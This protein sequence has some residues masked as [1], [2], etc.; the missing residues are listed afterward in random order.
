MN[1]YWQILI[2][3]VLGAAVIFL[4][5]RKRAMAPE[6]TDF[7][8]CQQAGG[9]LTDGDP[10]VCTIN[11]QTFAEDVN[12]EPEVVVDLPEY[13]ALVTSPLSVSGSARGSWF[14][15]AN[16]PVTLKDQ[17]GLVLAQKG[18]SAGGGS[19]FGGQ[20]NWMTED[21]VPFSGTLEFATPTTDFGVLII[22]KDNP[23]GDPQ[24]DAA[25][26]VPVRFK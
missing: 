25:F 4:V 17:N 3:V 7:A 6:A 8:T 22:N 11:G 15:E 12:Q 16:I 10:V 20:V 9:T 1:R 18:F 26:A 14:F 13:G 5:P 23:S 24:F 21:Y 2:L 19:A